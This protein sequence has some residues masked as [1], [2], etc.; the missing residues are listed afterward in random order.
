[1][2]DYFRPLRLNS[3]QWPYVIRHS[4]ASGTSRLTSAPPDLN[5]EDAMLDHG[6]LR[7]LLAAAAL[8]VGLVQPV[9]ADQPAPAPAVKVSHKTVKVGDL[10]IFYREA[11]PKD[12]PAI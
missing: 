7:F 4:D 9:T 1:M 12:A 3:V 6:S 11:G 8:S 10:D 2:A 5:R